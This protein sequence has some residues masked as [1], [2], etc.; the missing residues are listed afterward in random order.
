MFSNHYICFL[1]Y[2]DHPYNLTNHRRIG[3]TLQCVDILKWAP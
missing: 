3:S 1:V 2:H